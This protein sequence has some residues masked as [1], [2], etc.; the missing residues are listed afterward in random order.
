MKYV[1]MVIDLANFKDISIFDANKFNGTLLKLLNIDK[2]C[3]A[4]MM[5]RKTFSRRVSIHIRKF[6]DEDNFVVYE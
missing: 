3:A 1:K 2:L 5:A 4:P 6:S